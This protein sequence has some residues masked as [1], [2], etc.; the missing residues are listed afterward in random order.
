MP[1]PK[2]RAGLPPFIMDV[3]KEEIKKEYNI[4]CRIITE[5]LKFIRIPPDEDLERP[6]KEFITKTEHEDADDSDSKLAVTYLKKMKAVI[7]NHVHEVLEEW[8]KSRSFPHTKNQSCACSDL[9]E[10]DEGCN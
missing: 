1:P 5:R 3:L 4:Q 7:E 8:T 9:P 6:W 10:E 2:R